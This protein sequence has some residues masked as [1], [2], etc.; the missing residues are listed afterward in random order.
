MLESYR[1]VL[2][3]RGAKA[4]TLAGA[5][6]RLPQSMTGLG[7]ILLVTERGGSYAAAGLVS[8]AY[9]IAAAIGA[10]VQG[11]LADR[12][13]Q[14][15]VLMTA[16]ALFASGLCLVMLSVGHGTAPVMLAAVVAGLGAPGA[17]NMV[18]ARWSHV[19]TDRRELGSAFALEA[20]LDEAVFIVGPVLV[21]FLTLN[22]LDV[23]GLVVAASCALLGGWL[24]AAQRSTAPPRSARR[25]EDKEPLL[26]SLLGPIVAAAFALGVLFGSAE[27]LVVA[28]ASEDGHRQASG[29]V[30]AIWSIGSLVAG[31]V[32]GT[33]P[34]AK[35]PVRRLRLTTVALA[36]LFVPLPFAP[37]TAVLAIG[38]LATGLMVAPTLITAVHLVD[39]HTPGS[40]LTEAL[41]W[42]TTGLA[43]G[44]A[45]GAALAG[46]LV[47]QYSA[48]T[49]FL[50]P[51]AAGAMAAVVARLYEAPAEVTGKH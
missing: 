9:V 46:W 8:A 22:L 24:L 16:S 14:A 47:D 4:F 30:L 5:L 19:L 28:F 20:M 26:W 6:G 48:S 51:M 36:V 31:F 25:G 35:D 3:V 37:S 12:H 18:R 45:P 29:V 34:P 23:S 2:A 49:G 33:L 38:M 39:L 15:V 13:G 21:T 43:T 32:V 44:V 7:I 42:T 41:S 11:R 1:S 40:R 10:P 27:V 17:G 50:V